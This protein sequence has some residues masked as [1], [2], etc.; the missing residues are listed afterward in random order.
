MLHR[1]LQRLTFNRHA[2]ERARCEVSDT[3][4]GGYCEKPGTQRTIDGLLLCEAHARH[5]GLEERIACWEAILLHIELWSKAAR[6]RGRED[7]VRLLQLE[8]AEAA[9]ALARAHEELEK[10][11]NEG[12]EPKKREIYG[13]M[14]RGMS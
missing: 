10:A 14:S 3:L 1:T 6:R 2:K 7:I 12:Y 13:F 9:A 11:E 5:F 8:R 4:S